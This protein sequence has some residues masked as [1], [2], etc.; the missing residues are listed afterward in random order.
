MSLC[1][2]AGA[3]TTALVIAAFTLSW[4]H[5]VEKTRWEEDWRVTSAGLV[6]AEA[7]IESLGAGMD[8]PDG[9]RFDGRWWRWTP[10]LPALPEIRLARSE[11]VPEGWRLCAAG[12]CRAVADA[13]ETADVVMLVP[14][15]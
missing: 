10:R 14:C 13:A 15:P 9:A 3:K 5:S 11:A 2:I 8:A 12:E 6:L 4:T 1:L 7:R